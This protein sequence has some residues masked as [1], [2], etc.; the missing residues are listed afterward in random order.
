M[1]SNYIIIILYIEKFFVLFKSI[2]DLEACLDYCED[3][4]RSYEKLNFCFPAQ[5][6]LS[7]WLR[8]QCKYLFS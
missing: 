3:P 2:S 5:T 6:E 8:I 4:T 1:R 7:Y